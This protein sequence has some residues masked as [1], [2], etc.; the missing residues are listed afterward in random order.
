MLYVFFKLN[1]YHGEDK[2]MLV[3]IKGFP[4]FY[5][6][7][8][9][10]NLAVNKNGIILDLV[11][12]K[13]KLTDV[14]SDGYITTNDGGV[15]RNVHRIMG[16]TFLKRPS[17]KGT[18]IINHKDGDKTNPRLDN[19]EWVTYSGNIEHAYANGLRTDNTPVEVYNLKTDEIIKFI[20]IQQCAKYFKR[21][22]NA[23][24]KYLK[25]KRNAPFMLSYS[26]RKVGEGWPPLTK[27]DI[28]KVVNGA[29]VSIIAVNVSTGE[30]IIFSGAK[31]ASEYLG[32]KKSGIGGNLRGTHGD[33]PYH[34]YRFYH[35]N[36]YNLESTDNAID[37]RDPQSTKSKGKPPRQKPKMVSAFNHD[38]GIEDVFNSMRVFAESVGTTYDAI[39]RSVW[40]NAGRWKN[41]TIKYIG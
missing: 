30:K 37:V 24:V 23:I 8:G 29:P 11:T 18:Y 28:G 12:R 9:T 4:G 19:L 7:V 36:T 13:Y 35:L 14:A 21:N 26:I 5:R 38:T 3:E 17:G 31:A 15:T 2:C 6:A 41:Y 27:N 10:T 39:A 32:L 20:S 16:D 33:K 40:K 1:K 25:S 22:H 34:G